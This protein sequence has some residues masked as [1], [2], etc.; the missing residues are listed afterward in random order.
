M[1]P[2]SR[3]LTVD[4][5]QKRLD[6]GELRESRELEFKRQFP[7]KNE[8]LAKAL[9]ALAADGGAL[10]IGV[11]DRTHR[12]S[13]ISL[14]GARERIEGRGS[15]PPLRGIPGRGVAQWLVDLACLPQRE[16]QHRQACRDR[17]DGALLRVTL[18]G[19][20]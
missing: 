5:L 18:P 10:V 1:P 9:A 12:L 17:D 4:D 11:A 8:R 20:A 6:A 16:Q 14:D 19:P 7:Q 13:P 2:P 3:P 15:S